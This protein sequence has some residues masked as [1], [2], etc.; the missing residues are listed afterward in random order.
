MRAFFVALFAVGAGASACLADGVA[1][2]DGEAARVRLDASAAR[3]DEDVAGP[4][5]SAAAGVTVFD[6]GTV[7]VVGGVTGEVIADV[8]EG[9]RSLTLLV[10]SSDEDAHVVV[11]RAAVDGRVV[12]D[13]VEIDD[14]SALVQR[15]SR[16]FA[17]PFLSERRVLAAQG[18]G[19]FVFAR[20]GADDDGRWRLRV[21]QGLVDVDASGAVTQRP[22][23]GA[24]HLVGVVDERVIDERAARLRLPIVWHRAVSV[25]DAFIATAT[26]TA[27]RIWADVGVDLVVEAST[28]VVSADF[29][30]LTL[31]DDLCEEGELQSLLRSLPPTPGALDIVLIERFECLVRGG[32]VVRGIAGLTAAVP[33]DAFVDGGSHGGLALA[34]DV[35]GADAEF[36]GV[37]FAHE[38]GHALGLF[39]TV[40]Q[41]SGADPL[42]FDDVD[43][44]A[45]DAAVSDNLMVAVPTTQTTLTPQQQSRA[46]S[47]PWLVPEQ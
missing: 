19:A 3:A 2:D 33:A 32:V 20:R 4:A 14:A 34:H 47:S 43:D 22:R 12:V 36:A 28:E 7:A 25:D 42:V 41:A 16:G 21:R 15:L 40:E 11:D 29:A 10:Q 39:H 9:V 5:V 38:V 35:V 1:D 27:A 30:V 37:V 45:N 46:R 23:D 8:D 18:S 26:A 24:V 17:G 31:R 44:T 6:L 13:A